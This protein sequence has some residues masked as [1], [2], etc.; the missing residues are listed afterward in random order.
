MDPVA[1]KFHRLHDAGLIIQP[2]RPAFPDGVFIQ[3][4]FSQLDEQV[5]V[6]G[7]TFHEAAIELPQVGIVETFAKPLEPFAASGFNKGEGEELIE[8]AL[9]FTA[10]LAF[11]FPELV[12]VKVFS[13]RPQAERTFLQFREDEPEMSPL[14][15]Y[16]R[17]KR[18]DQALAGGVT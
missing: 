15:C 7:F 1:A 13:L 17:G 4:C 12:D 3:I 11:K 6:A 10:A 5:I 8:E 16:D 9:D 14:L 18:F 2:F